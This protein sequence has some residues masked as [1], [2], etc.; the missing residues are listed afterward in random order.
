MT[1][2]LIALSGFFAT[3]LQ[4][5]GATSTCVGQSEARSLYRAH[6]PATSDHL[7]TVDLSES[8]R[9]VGGLGFVADGIAALVFTT[10]VPDS[11]R[12]H[13]FYHPAKYDHFYSVNE[14]EA[15]NAVAGGYVSEDVPDVTPIYVYSSPLCDTMPFY[16]LVMKDSDHL[17]TVNATERDISQQQGWTFEGV[18]GYVYALGATV[19]STS[20]VSSVNT[21]APSGSS[22]SLSTPRKKTPIGAIVGG[23]IGGVIGL[24]VVVLAAFWGCRGRRRH[25]KSSSH[26]AVNPQLQHSMTGPVTSVTSFHATSPAPSSAGF[27]GVG[28][29]QEPATLPIKRHP[30]PPPPQVQQHQDSGVRYGVVESPPEYTR[31]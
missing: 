30:R 6:N 20:R 16:R 14:T 11:V 17:Y 5:S 27:A 29:H 19:S 28:I 18:A 21:K 10:Q 9:A 24:I 26:Y 25:D 4:V 13:R 22:S 3:V 2:F 12:L 15:A 8:Q 1:K 7:Y 23:T 31:D